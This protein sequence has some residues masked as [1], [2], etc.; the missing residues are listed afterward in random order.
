MEGTTK[1][2]ISG[3][4]IIWYDYAISILH[5]TLPSIFN[6]LFSEESEF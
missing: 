2:L 4:I 6:S 5:I 1:D 3:H